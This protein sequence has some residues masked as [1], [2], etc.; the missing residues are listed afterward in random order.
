VLEV[1]PCF[2]SFDFGACLPPVDPSFCVPQMGYEF[3]APGVHHILGAMAARYPGLP[4]VISEA[5][6]ATHE[7]RR[8]AE[9][10]VRVL[11][12]IAR[13]RD[14]GVD[15]RGYYYWS[16][17]DNFE[18]AEGYE[19]RFGLF[20]VDY[21]SYGRTPTVGAEVLSQ[22]TAGRRLTSEMR[23]LYGGEGPMTPDPEHDPAA[24]FCG[25]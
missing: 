16:L 19:P 20:H 11:E 6:I 23:A 18:W 7:G 17:T 2:A 9:N 21:A 10:V 12:Q 5:G 14:E 25:G 8:R 3:Y 4:L 13:A 24:A 22:I 15:V 1:T